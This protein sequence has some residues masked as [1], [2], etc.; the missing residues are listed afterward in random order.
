M[1]KETDRQKNSLY[2]EGMTSIRAVINSI[3]QGL[4]NRR[5]L[6]VYYDKAKLQKIK[7]KRKNV[8]FGK[9]RF[10]G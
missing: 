10:L 9:L 7:Q 2:F 8:R 4:S 6:K 1:I 3:D 5:I